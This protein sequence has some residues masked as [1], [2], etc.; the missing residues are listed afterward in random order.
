ML[1]TGYQAENTLGRKLQ[2]GMENVRIF[3]IPDAG[4]SAIES[5]DELSGHADSGELLDWMKPMTATLKRVFL[6]H[7]ENES[8]LAL[9]PRDPGELW[10]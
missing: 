6:V 2:D 1:L 4:A 8:A 10:H 3:G 7:G 9:S 5:L